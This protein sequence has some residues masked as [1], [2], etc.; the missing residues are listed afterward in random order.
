MQMLERC[1]LLER[2]IVAGKKAERFA[3]DDAN[4][5]SMQL[6]GMLLAEGETP[7]EEAAAEDDDDDDDDD[8]EGDDND[9]N[10]DNKPR[11]ANEPNGRR[12]G[13]RKLPE[14]LPRVE[15]EVVPP[16]VIQQHGLDAF[17]RIG[18]VAS[19]T[20]E[21]RPGSLVVV[22]IIRP[23]F[24]RKDVKS[25]IQRRRGR[26]E[27]ELPPVR[28]RRAARA[29]DRARPRGPEP[30]RGDDRAAVAGPPAGE[31]SGGDLGARGPAALALDDL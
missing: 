26:R 10:D 30:A 12:R 7:T 1:R 28:D 8:D 31:S 3:G 17:V 9:D 11:G 27:P 4:Q 18:E 2:G 20:V 14:A 23:K 5:L 22:R 24:V 25:R 29:A 21:R 6:L 19:E 16:E 15:V 13:R